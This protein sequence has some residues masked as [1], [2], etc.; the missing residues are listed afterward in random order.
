MEAVAK[1]LKDFPFKYFLTVTIY[2]KKKNNLW[3]ASLPN[4]N[5]IV[6]VIKNA[7]QLNLVGMAKP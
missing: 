6:P 1:A 5:L 2:Q 7:D 3:R 4:G